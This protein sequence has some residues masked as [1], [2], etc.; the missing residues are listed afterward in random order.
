VWNWEAK[1]RPA[2][3]GGKGKRP[4][5]FLPAGAL[6]IGGILLLLVGHHR[7]LGGIL[8]GL[9]AFS[10]GV[11]LVYPPALHWM[12]RFGQALGHGVGV[13]LTWLLLAP[14]YLTFFSLARLVLALTGKDPLRREFPSPDASLWIPRE[15][16][17]PEGY[18]SQF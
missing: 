18:R 3:D 5:D 13:A 4:G 14:F 1:N 15:P 16:S 12:K 17:P 8:L 10:F 6:A 11:G 2:V 9:S 7:L